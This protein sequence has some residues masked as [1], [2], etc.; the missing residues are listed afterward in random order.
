MPQ[1]N[2]AACINC[3]HVIKMTGLDSD[4]P[5]C[6][7]C[8]GELTEF[9][10]SSAQQAL[11]LPQNEKPTESVMSAR[12][13]T[14]T[15]LPQSEPLLGSAEPPGAVECL[16]L[17]GYEIVKM[18]GHGG[19][20]HVL[21]GRQLSLGGRRVAVKHLPDRLARNAHFVARFRQEA[22]VLSRLS[23][24]NIVSV[25]DCRSV[26]NSTFLIMEYVEGP[27]GTPTD[28]SQLIARADL[29]EAQ[30]R[31]LI[32]QILEA[33]ASAHASSI[34]HRD[35]K[36]GNVMLDRHQNAKVVDFGIASLGEIETSRALTI[37]GGRMGTV[38]YM[39]PEQAADARNVDGRSDLYSC[40]VM[41]YEMLTRRLPR[42]A[43]RPPSKVVPG[44][45]PE[46]DEIIRRALQPDPAERF[47]TAAEMALAI[48]AVDRAETTAAERASTAVIDEM[49]EW[50]SA[51][52]D[53][54]LPLDVRFDHARR[55]LLA[56]GRTQMRDAHET[57]EELLNQAHRLAVALARQGAERGE[58]EKNYSAA[59][60][61]R[62]FLTQR[63]PNDLASS[64]RLEE[65]EARRQ[66]VLIRARELL[67]SGEVQRCLRGLETAQRRFPED[68]ELERLLTECRE[69]M[70]RLDEGSQ[71]IRK[72]R[73]ERRLLKLLECVNELCR[74]PGGARRFGTLRAQ[75]VPRVRKVWSEV[76]RIQALMRRQ[77]W[78][79]AVAAAAELKETV[80]DCP[81]VQQICESLQSVAPSQPRG[82]GVLF[83]LSTMIF[84]LGILVVGVQILRPQWMHE[85]RSFV[86]ARLLKSVNSS[87][88]LSAAVPALPA[89]GP[90]V[91]LTPIPAPTGAPDPVSTVEQAFEDFAEQWR[92]G[93]YDTA[94][95]QLEEIDVL[96][97]AAL[98]REPRNA[99]LQEIAKQ[100]RLY[101]VQ[102]AALLEILELLEFSGTALKSE[103]FA[104]ARQTVAAA[105]AAAQ[106]TAQNDPKL[107]L[108]GDLQERIAQKKREIDQAER[109]AAITSA[110]RTT[111]EMMARRDYH[112]A[113]EALDAVDANDP[114]VVSLRS[115]IDQG[116]RQQS[117]TV[118]VR[119]DA[120][121]P[122]ELEVAIDGE[123]VAFERQEASLR[124]EVPA[125]RRL[126]K[127]VAGQ[128][129]MLTSVSVAE[130]Q[131][132]AID[133]ALGE[134]KL[135]YKLGPHRG[136]V[137]Y[138]AL[139]P[140]GR[141]H[142]LTS[143]GRT[144]GA[145]AFLF[146]DLANGQ[147]LDGVVLGPRNQ[148]P[149]ELPRAMAFS[150]DGKLMAW[151]WKVQSNDPSAIRLFST[152]APH[153][154]IQQ[155]ALFTNDSGLDVTRMLLSH[156]GEQVLAWDQKNKQ[157]VHFDRNQLEWHNV[158]QYLDQI[159]GYC[160]AADERHC[161]VGSADG[162]SPVDLWSLEG[163]RS[164]RVRQYHDFPFASWSVTQS[165]DGKH[166][167]AAGGRSGSNECR[168][169]IWDFSTAK[170][171]ASPHVTLGDAV[172]YVSLTHDADYVLV[173]TRSGTVEI[174]DIR[175]EERLITLATSARNEIR[176]LS[177]ARNGRRLLAAGS[178]GFVYYFE[179]PLSL[180]TTS[181]AGVN[182]RA[183]AGSN[184]PSTE[185]RSR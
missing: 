86:S 100:V 125:G 177:I 12:E 84:L 61:Y 34:V 95:T 126:M 110:V 47:P 130:R 141:S 83:R 102:L 2:V 144:T 10:S 90:M 65:L 147:S 145:G 111:T 87:A 13:S 25:Y 14:E 11:R 122:S 23:H 30:V 72:L 40:G 181:P 121:V 4:Y 119:F 85:A 94:T 118:L 28:L 60:K 173:G 109:E 91:G 69:E 146:W 3:G 169:A 67:N 175:R 16:K 115:Q 77:E 55:A 49:A 19:M 58:R 44:L 98:E 153:F 132:T 18:I 143:T 163:E 151:L 171:I 152:V 29:D 8:G 46:W 33:L 182:D 7:E 103:D 99:R 22:Q 114:R 137:V 138:A 140:D 71:Q 97:A 148:P 104:T 96:M 179:L 88:T 131:I 92:R 42:G 164:R 134:A 154:A 162:Q 112:A 89:A 158:A 105:E 80:T 168:L 36:P 161:I 21:E 185:S 172:S 68:Q 50:L 120:G 142:A 43:F 54:G 116:I 128:R 157:L 107:S 184:E 113:A 123:P 52:D 20:G 156:A 176:C 9:S 66:K 79:A 45:N 82:R 78:D 48:D 75:L 106:R 32:L 51:A 63:L 5:I 64:R 133:A 150:P 178:D 24:P 26:G 37:A 35:I 93:A 31:R 124:L 139:S 15:V 167:V 76:D 62:A 56:L 129:R 135:I 70:Q 149:S 81:E 27:A 73:I 136:P 159:G 1:R 74:T 180:Q 183:T 59:V 53:H 160:F 174:F 57:R 6:P 101:R 155:P 17:A 165:G 108:P 117:G 38:D 41:L 170:L 166:L 39:S 127:L